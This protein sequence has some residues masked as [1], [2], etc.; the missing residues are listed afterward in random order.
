[1]VEVEL[2]YCNTTMVT[3]HALLQL[4]TW[5]NLSHLLSPQAK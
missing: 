5:I 3:I 4:H 1:M 2:S